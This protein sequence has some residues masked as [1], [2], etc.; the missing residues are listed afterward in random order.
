VNKVRW[1]SHSG[2]RRSTSIIS[3]DTS[4]FWFS[5]QSSGCWSSKIFRR[6]AQS[7]SGEMNAQNEF[8][9]TLQ[10]WKNSICSS[11]NLLDHAKTDISFS[12]LVQ[13]SS[14]LFTPFEL[15][16]HSSNV[17]YVPRRFIPSL[18]EART[19][20]LQVRNIWLRRSRWTKWDEWLILKPI[21][22]R[23]YYL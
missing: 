14:F 19:N 22:Q 9:Q 11:K 2:M 20:G 6:R 12:D 8:Q 15:W 18:L 4:D 17:Y 5:R 10:R 13:E 3:L 23:L 16:N 21:N 7:E 1:A